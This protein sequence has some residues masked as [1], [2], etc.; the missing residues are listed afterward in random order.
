ML[1]RPSA[2][3]SASVSTSANAITSIG[4]GTKA[5][6]TAGTLEM[7][8][9]VDEPNATEPANTLS[10]LDDDDGIYSNCDSDPPNT[11][12]HVPYSSD[13]NPSDSVSQA[14][15]QLQVPRRQKAMN[16]R[17]WVFD[18][19]ILTLLDVSYTDKRTGERVQD[20][21]YNANTVAGLQ[22]IRSAIVLRI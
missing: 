9:P 3:P 19:F 1:H 4:T 10:F 21:Q 17:S 20:R 8:N 22:S 5:I 2:S 12:I 18:H 13:I 14:P 15:L 11:S 7:A 16:P 6:D